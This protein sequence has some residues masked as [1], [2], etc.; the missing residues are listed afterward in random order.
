MRA[1][2][3]PLLV[4]LA[5]PFVAAQLPANAADLPLSHLLSLAQT[6]L[7]SGKTSTA[8]SIYDHCLERDRSDFTTLYKRATIRLASG[9]Y[10]K[11]KEGFHEVLAVREYEP[12]HFQLGKIYVKLGEYQE[13][14][15]ELDHYLK[16]VK[17]KEDKEVKEAQELRKQVLAAEKD[18]AVARKALSSSPPNLDRC[19]SATSS[20]ISLSPHSEELRLLRADCALLAHDFDTTVADLS[21]ASALSPALPTHLQLR[22]ALISSLFLDHGLDI[23]ADSLLALKKCLNADPDSKPCRQ[24]FKA[25]KGAEK[26]LSKLRNWVEAGRWTE[27]AVMMAGS[28]TKEGLIP[29]VRGLIATYQQPVTPSVPATAPLPADPSLPRSSPLLT[30]LLSTLCHAYLALQ[31]RK[32]ASACAEI[33]LHDPEDTWGLVGKAEVLMND[34]KWDEAVQVLSA[35]FEATGRS[36]RDVLSRL[37]KAQRLL[38]QS[39]A[40]DYYK[41][42]GVSRD[43]DAKTIKRAYRKATLKAHPDKE[44]GSEE[45]MAALNEAYEVL[46]NEELRARFDAGEDPNDPTSGQSG[47]PGG[48]GGNPVFFQQGGSPFGAGGHPFQQFFQGGGGGFPGGGGGQ[49]Y[50]FS[51]LD[52]TSPNSPPMDTDYDSFPPGPSTTFRHRAKCL[53]GKRA[54]RVAAAPAHAS[55]RPHYDEDSPW[56]GSSK[57]VGESL[58]PTRKSDTALNEGK[59]GAPRSAGGEEDE[60]DVESNASDEVQTIQPR[61]AKVEQV[62]QPFPL[63]HLHISV[64]SSVE[65]VPPQL[66]PPPPQ[67]PYLV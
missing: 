67:T 21:R 26:E 27:A 58:P 4:L 32:S 45:K 31:N 6:A 15:K 48:G 43:A 16:A 47:F 64:I 23:P 9:Q 46:S 50:Q 19:I 34:E 49:Q 33:L 44:G 29:T 65:F 36:D 51:P 14:R 22:I 61:L 30:S 60:G 37:Q 35:A 13:A 12:A 53:Y 59:E 39:K 7:A 55:S 28:S 56:S 66:P 40:K 20:A 25:L 17:G 1:L 10:G 18:L 54:R 8:L 11:A 57:K 5:L 62:P 41:V 52:P 24:A 63:Y 42:L 38:K 3:L 2:A